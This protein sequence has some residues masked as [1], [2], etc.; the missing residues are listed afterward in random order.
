MSTQS[1][2]P[3]SLK[4]KKV[5]V[6][7]HNGMVGSALVRRLVHEDCEVITV[8]RHVVDLMNEVNVQKWMTDVRPDMVFVAAARVGGI[9][10]N[11]SYPA[12]FLHENLVIQNNIIHSAHLADVQKLLFLGSSCIYPRLAPQPIEEEALLTGPLEPTN[13]WYAVA[14]IAGI[15]MCQA[16]RSQYGRDFISAMPT[17]LYGENDN[18]D[19]KTSHVAA[20]LMVKI[21]SATME[22]KDTVEIWG[23]GNPLREFLHVDD[24]ADALVFLA[25]NYSDEK[26]INVG[27]GVEISIRELAELLSEIIS[28]Q[29]NYVFDTS[30]PDGTPRKLMDSARLQQL[31][32]VPKLN[33]RDGMS[34]TYGMYKQ[35]PYVN[36]Q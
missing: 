1:N 27:S 21:H 19:L 36:S 4:D 30:K 24:L 13:E 25:E 12:S 14:K 16:Y 26:H 15:K 10:A 11:N 20:A 35:L 5:W 2:S 23:T 7:G 17:N 6:A 33:L 22:Q 34:R 9:L 31:G 29:G 18:Y 32:W 8:E 3:Y 28:F